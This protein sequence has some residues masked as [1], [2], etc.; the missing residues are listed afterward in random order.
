MSTTTKRQICE[1]AFAEL[2]LAGN[3]FD[4]S[5][6][7]MQTALVRLDRMVAFWETKGIALGYAMPDPLLGSRLD[8]ESGVPAGAVQA[9]VTNLAVR[10]AAVWG[11][12]LSQDTRNTAKQGYDAL[13]AQ[14]AAP[15]DQVFPDTLPRGA[16]NKPWRYSNPFFGVPNRGPLLNSE[17]GALDITQG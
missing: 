17:G 12:E 15:R 10:L 13:L 8:D 4:L 14:A 7:E 3:V 1:D 11:K 9:L 6:E 2:A 5:P 16:G